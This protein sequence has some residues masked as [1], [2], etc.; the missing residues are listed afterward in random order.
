MYKVARRC[1]IGC[2]LYSCAMPEFSPIQP[3][4][5]VPYPAV[6]QSVVFP[7]VA[8]NLQVH[9][10]GGRRGKTSTSIDHGIFR[11]KLVVVSSGGPIV[12]F[13]VAAAVETSSG[14]SFSQ[15]SVD[16]V[17]RSVRICS[18]QA[19]LFCCWLVTLDTNPVQPTQG[20]PGAR[21]DRGL[22]ESLYWPLCS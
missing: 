22:T 2:G 16:D 17:S 1:C 7:G 9:V 21:L 5:R 8:T 19:A 4:S 13:G 11:G 12:G 3:M 20:V 6:L 14:N 10:M 15:F 18:M